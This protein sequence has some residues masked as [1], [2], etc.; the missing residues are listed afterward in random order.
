[1]TSIFGMLI[2]LGGLIFFHELGHYLVAKFFRIKVEIF[3]LGFGKKI[4]KKKWGE[5][6]YCVSLIPL[7]GY[8]KMMGDDPY[9]VIPPEEADRAFSTQALYKRFAVVAAGPIANLLLAYVLF[10]VVFW[11]GQPQVST[12][13]GAVELESSAWQSGFRPEDKILSLNEQA[14]STW[15]DLEEWTRS[16]EGQTVQ[17]TVQR[18]QTQ[19]KL[20]VPITKVQTKNSYGEEETVGGIKGISPTPLASVVG[21]SN[22]E[23]LAYRAGLRTGDYITKVGSKE[24]SS[25]EEL[26]RELSLQWQASQPVELAYQSLSESKKKSDDKKTNLIFP[27]QKENEWDLYFGFF[28]AETFVKQ[29]SKDSPAEK[30][31]LTAGDRIMKIGDI[32]VSHFDN[33]VES[34]QSYGA[35]GNSVP[36]VI[37]RLGKSI[38]LDLK[39]VETTQEDPITHNKFKKYI[40]G[41]APYL[42][43]EEPE[44]TTV[45]IRQLPTLFMK[46]I[47]ET[48]ELA[49]KMVVSLGKLATGGISL[50]NLG[51]PVLIATV[52]GKS[53]DAGLVH[54]L[55]TMAL[56]SINLFLLNLFPVPILDGGHLLFFTIEA[57]KGKPVTIRT[58][59]IA[60]QIGMVFILTLVVLTLF[61]DISRII[62]H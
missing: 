14:V 40:I 58:M 54:F 8:V 4:L 11:V 49:Y 38:T 26:K 16:K 39:P 29:V 19:V 22:P 21:I 41:F 52:A 7:G 9:K 33:I 48:N 35:K 32:K 25:F 3:S 59:E 55:Q 56:I 34:V 20:S 23:T 46:A 13:V 30:G 17:V 31:G 12:R 51:G 24:V 18:D 28:P 10:M 62:L 47:G 61:N 42:V 44:Y 43:F 57:L 15:Q 60:N 6:E 50:K 36:V 2:L 27:A 37:E 53:L 5:T 1:M 45:Q